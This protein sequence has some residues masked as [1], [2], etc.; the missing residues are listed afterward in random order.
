MFMNVFLFAVSILPLLRGSQA[1]LAPICERPSTSMGGVM[2]RRD[3]T[4]V[5]RES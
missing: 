4:L 1:V 3:F 5:Y 2:R